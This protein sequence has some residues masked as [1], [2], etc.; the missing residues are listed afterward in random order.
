LLIQE[1]HYTDDGANLTGVLIQDAHQTRRRP[2]VLV[3]HGG[4]GLDA[5]ARK[6]AQRLADAGYVAFACDMYGGDVI[7]HR[8]KIVREINAFR[9]DR[10]RLTTR[11]NAGLDVLASHA[12]TDRRIAVVGYCFGGLVALELARG[13]IA[14][15][16]AVSV[17]GT[18]TTTQ[19]LETRAIR[20]PILACQGALDPHCSLAD[21][22]RFADEMRSLDADWEM[23]VYGRAMHGFTHEDATGQMP[24]VQ[25]DADADV[26]SLSVIHAFLARA[27]ARVC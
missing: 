19:P 16:A 22:M 24:G 20:T 21:S 26:R 15:A 2:G 4:A 11:A 27:F 1:I 7:G 6:Q 23:V 14:L 9:A 8:E 17:H 10:A 25:Y 5:H 13:G 3:V 12:D 18:L